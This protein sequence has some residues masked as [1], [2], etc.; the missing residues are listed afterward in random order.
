MSFI[1][2][3]RYLFFKYVRYRQ[4]FINVGTLSVLSKVEPEPDFYTGSDSATLPTRREIVIKD[5]EKKESIY[6]KNNKEV[7][8]QNWIKEHKSV[9]KMSLLLIVLTCLSFFT[10]LTENSFLLVSPVHSFPLLVNLSLCSIC[11]I[12][13][14]FFPFLQ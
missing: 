9:R 4:S 10:S 3:Y 12:G 6:K 14:T 1:Y 5:E 8:V 13:F 11:L 7:I 2:K